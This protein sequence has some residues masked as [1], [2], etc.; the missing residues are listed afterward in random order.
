M[1]WMLGQ[2][3]ESLE[4]VVAQYLWY[5]WVALTHKFTSLMKIFVERVFFTE[6]ENMHP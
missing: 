3:V 6:T 5:L 4:F 2:A 1:G